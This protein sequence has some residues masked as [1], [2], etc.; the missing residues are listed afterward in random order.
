MGMEEFQELKKEA[1]ERLKNADHLITM[2]YPLVKDNRL[3]LA[4]IDNL[5]QALEL[6]LA[7]ILSYELKYQRVPPFQE[8]LPSRIRLF[9]EKVAPRY[10]I[11]KNYIKLITDLEEI[12]KFRKDSPVEFN[13]G[14]KYIIA[15][16][17]FKL[18]EITLPVTKDYLEKAKRFIE[19]MEI[20]V[21]KG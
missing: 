7:S 10:K 6:S 9:S 13:R 3:L 19:S 16:P 21:S 5:L 17:E 18:R 1:R 20:L 14:D 11:D 8:D 4:A 2:T 12:I 15:S